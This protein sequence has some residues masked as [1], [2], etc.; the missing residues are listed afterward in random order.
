MASP[1]RVVWGIGTGRT[2]RAHWALIEL[3]LEY[4][5]EVVRTRT[6]DMDTPEFVAT[7]PRRKIP[8]LV[9]GDVCI[10]ESS[11]IVTYLAERYSDPESPLIPADIAKRAKY[12][13]WLSFVCMEL[14]A[15]SLYVLRRHDDLTHIYGEAPQ[16]VHAAQE[17][18]QRMLGAATVIFDPNA[19]YVLG[20]TFS[21]ADILFATVLDWTERYN[22]PIPEAF[23]E[24]RVRIQNRQAY[25]RAM[26]INYPS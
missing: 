24:Y 7:N 2:I 26:A 21:G 16:A 11:A 20:D 12:F 23:D 25:Q 8:V 14:D 17:Y 9:D 10:A 3:D 1:E 13:E 22:Q 5:I 6:P 4:R 18:L 19:P 15:T